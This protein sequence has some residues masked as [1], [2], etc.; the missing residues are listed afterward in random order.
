MEKSCKINSGTYDEYYYKDEECTPWSITGTSLKAYK[1]N[2]TDVLVDF[3]LTYPVYFDEEGS[4]EFKYR[5]DTIGTQEGTY[6]IFKF[7]I[8]DFIQMTDDS[9]F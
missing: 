3:D 4:V 1:A 2:I 6:G 9:I 8:D 7:F 5:K